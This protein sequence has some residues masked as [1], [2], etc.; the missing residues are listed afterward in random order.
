M[1]RLLA[2]LHTIPAIVMGRRM[3]I[4]AWNDMAAAMMFDFGK[5]PPAQRN[6]VRLLF[7]DQRMRDLY[8]DWEA[9]AQTAVAQ[10]RMEAAKNP[11][12][13]RMVQ[14]VGELSMQ[15]SQFSTWWA[16]RGVATLSTGRKTLFHP[17]VGKLILD[18][19]TLV[20][21]D[22]AEQQLVIWTG[23]PGS[24]TLAALKRLSTPPSS[25]MERE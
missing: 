1:L 3:D 4:L 23:E 14:I 2:D 5:I 17:K 18:W 13:P 20:E 16:A 19:D 9:V 12:D 10:L 21:A 24:D 11:D 22:D 8:E 6:Y 7:S 25:L 15:D